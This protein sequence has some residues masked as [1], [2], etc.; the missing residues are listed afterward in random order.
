MRTLNRFLQLLS[1]RQDIALAAVLIMAVFMIILPLPTAL[2][3]AL[4]A[5]NLTVSLLLLM[6]AVY[7]REPLEFSAFPSVLL[8]TTLFRLSLSISTTRL[9]LLQHD[10]GD[11]VYTFGNFVVGGNIGIGLI[12]FTIITIVQFIVITKGSE[13]VAEVGARFSLDGMPGKQMSIDGDMRAGIIDASEANLLRLRVQKESQ[14]YGAMDGAMKFVKGDA[15][16]SII[17]ILVNIFGGMAV[18]MFVHGMPAGESMRTYSVLSIG[19]G[20]I[21]QIP[22]LLISV[23]AGIIVT[24]V[25]G[26]KRQNL[27]QDL[28]EQMARHPKPLFLAAGMLLLFALLPGFPTVIFLVLAL[29]IAGSGWI[30]TRQSASKNQVGGGIADEDDESQELRPGSLPLVL[31]LPT[32]LYSPALQ[33][34]LTSLRWRVFNELG[35][36]IPEIVI[37]RRA[38]NTPLT[39]ELY[40]E[41]VFSAAIPENGWLD[42]HANADDPLAVR[43]HTGKFVR[44][45]DGENFN[46]VDKKSLQQ[47]DE[48]IIFCLEALIAFHAKEFIGVQETRVLMDGMESEYGELV[49]EVQRQLPL[50]KVTEVLQ[51]LAEEGISI[52]DLRTIFEALLVW[53]PKEKDVVILV[54]YIRTALRRHIIGRYQHPEEGLKAWLV[55]SGLEGM[56]RE[57]IRQTSSGAYSALDGD[58][59]ARILEEVRQTAGNHPE[60]VLLTAID[61]RRYLRRLVERE[62]FGLSV[63]SFQEI[64]DEAQLNILGNV[65]LI[66]DGAAV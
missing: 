24:R 33:A 66:G 61:V 14:L 11:I 8:I 63:L 50:A 23:T 13:R 39:V 32:Q 4:I 30:L 5:L 7:V 56:V 1:G 44:F 10:A 52:R 51:R 20:L 12:I 29:V 28:T 35:I 64:G 37:R 55:G 57:S 22:A 21:A 65:E 46:D 36:I 6:I 38:Q 18:G 34:R 42:V 3:D 2:I 9:I 17:I 48:Q 19:D 53:A 47:G 26:E 27:G 43:L 49:K 41:T 59:I 45:H 15:I 40:Q 62:F 25:P 60:G 16:A 31:Q 58:Q 54:E